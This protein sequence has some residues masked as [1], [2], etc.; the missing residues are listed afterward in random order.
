ML[1]ELGH[2]ASQ[3]PKTEDRFVELL[4]GMKDSCVTIISQISQS[5]QNIEEEGGR[6]ALV[7]DP[8]M[9]WKYLS[10][11]FLNGK[12]VWC[13]DNGMAYLL[14]FQ[15]ESLCPRRHGGNNSRRN[16]PSVFTIIVAWT[17]ASQNLRRLNEGFWDRRQIFQDGECAN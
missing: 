1:D 6:L 11:D 14:L 4:G 12:S 10:L 2:S 8:K 17:K 3:D 15:A 7:V 16:L 13:K 9:G 5:L